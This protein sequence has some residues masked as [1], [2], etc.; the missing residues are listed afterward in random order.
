MVCWKTGKMEF[1]SDNET[2]ETMK[3]LDPNGETLPT[4]RA[5]S[6]TFGDSA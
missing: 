5:V 6:A 1:T 2:L 3:Q 4:A